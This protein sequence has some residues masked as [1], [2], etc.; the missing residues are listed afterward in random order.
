M[1][2]SIIPRVASNHTTSSMHLNQ[3]YDD[4][5]SSLSHQHLIGF[6][7]TTH[8]LDMIFRQAI[9]AKGWRGKMSDVIIWRSSWGK[10]LLAIEIGVRIVSSDSVRDVAILSR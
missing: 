9:V 4:I 3:H 8:S 7:S 6:I 1:T 2:H 10:K 5:S